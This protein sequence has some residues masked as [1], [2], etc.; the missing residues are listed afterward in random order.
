MEMKRVRPGLTPIGLS[1]VGSVAAG[2]DA[3]VSSNV[4]FELVEGREKWKS[5]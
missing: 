1:M 2:E 3:E 5:K 4:S